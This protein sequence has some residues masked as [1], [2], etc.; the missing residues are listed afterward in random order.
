M[1]QSPRSIRYGSELLGCCLQK[2]QKPGHHLCDIHRHELP[3]CQVPQ[4]HPASL[5]LP[6]CTYRILQGVGSTNGRGDCSQVG[7]F[8]FSVGCDAELNQL[9]I[10]INFHLLQSGSTL[11]QGHWGAASGGIRAFCAGGRESPQRSCASWW[12][13]QEVTK[14]DALP[15]VWGE[16]VP[17]TGKHGGW[18]VAEN[19]IL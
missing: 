16:S 12:V 13:S 19:H 5:W 11:Q 6:H 4:C 14:T 3:L 8:Y 15:V 10:L 17:Q 9:F 7:C 2:R 18:W 1:F